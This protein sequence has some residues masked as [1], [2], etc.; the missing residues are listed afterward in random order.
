MRE[1]VKT[2]RAI[3]NLRKGNA[4]GED[5][6]TAEHLKADLEFTTDK[7]K[8]LIDMIWKL[9]KVPVKWKRGS[10]LGY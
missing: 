9:E 5:L 3:N 4:P 6:V 2:R 8:E 1:A 7:V 10:T